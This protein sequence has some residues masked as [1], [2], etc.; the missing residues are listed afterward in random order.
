MRTVSQTS[1]RRHPARD[2]AYLS[3]RGRSS[4]HVLR[5]AGY[6]RWSAHGLSPQD[7]PILHFET[8]HHQQLAVRAVDQLPAGRD[9]GVGD[10]GSRAP[11]L[12]ASCSKAIRTGCARRATAPPTRAT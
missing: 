2:H 1:R 3:A 5:P 9:R 10:P 12:R 4:R 8:D 7:P 11:S 6:R